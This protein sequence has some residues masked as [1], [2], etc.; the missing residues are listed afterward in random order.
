VLLNDFTPDNQNVK[1]S[2]EEKLQKI[3]VSQASEISQ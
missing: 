2:N 3:K 1:V